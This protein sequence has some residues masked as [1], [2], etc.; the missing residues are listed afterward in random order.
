[1]RILVEGR[2]CS[3]AGGE[4]RHQCHKRASK[5][6]NPCMESSWAKTEGTQA[7]TG[8]GHYSCGLATVG[9]H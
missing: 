2:E 8:Q 7:E 1:M 6:A 9:W 5:Q 3:I 4:R